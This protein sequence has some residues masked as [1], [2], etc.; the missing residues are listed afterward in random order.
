MMTEINS[1]EIFESLNITKILLAVLET[2][3]VVRIPA[4]NFLDAGNQDKELQVDYDEDTQDF[5]F[6]IKDI[7]NE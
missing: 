7:T 5:V 1:Q 3:K 2:N 4:L 6:K